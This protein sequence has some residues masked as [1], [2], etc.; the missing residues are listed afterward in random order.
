MMYTK[1]KYDICIMKI[2]Q[3]RFVN[4]I[5]FVVASSIAKPIKTRRTNRI[6]DKAK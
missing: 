3:F 1:V 5:Q 4:Y 6:C 2:A